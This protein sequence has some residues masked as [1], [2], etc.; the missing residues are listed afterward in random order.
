[1]SY[2][3]RIQR[4]DFQVIKEFF[5]KEKTEQFIF[6][7][8][9]KLKLSS[10]NIIY[11]VKE[12]IFPDE[13]EMSIHSKAFVAPERFFQLAVYQ[14]AC[15]K[16]Y[17]L[18]DLHNHW[19][20]KN[21]RFSEIDLSSALENAKFL[22]EHLPEI[23][24]GLAVVND[25]VNA[26]SGLVFDKSQNSFQPLEALEILGSP[27]EIFFNQEIAQEEKQETYAR[28][29]LIPNWKQKVLSDLK[30]AVVGAGGTGSIIIQALACLGV[31]E[32]K[33][34]IIIIDPDIIEK[35]NLSRIPYANE[36][37]IGKFKVKVAKNYIKQK[38][39]KINVIAIPK[40]VQEEKV[41]SF[42]KQAH[43]IIGAID[44]ENARKILNQI[45]TK[46]EVP[47]IDTGT[48]IIPEK[49]S[50]HA[51]G[52]VRIVLPRKG[53]L[54][55]INGIDLA[56]ASMEMLSEKTAQ[57]YE[58][59]GYIRGTNITPTPAVIH[60]NGVIS[61]LAISMLI[62]IIF[63]EN[64]KGQ[65]AIFYD[66]NKM[67]LVCADFEKNPKCVICSEAEEKEVENA[68][69]LSGKLQPQKR[70][71]NL[72]AHFHPSSA[73]LF[74]RKPAGKEHPGNSQQNKTHPCQ[75][76]SK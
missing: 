1:M 5:L 56:E 27:T 17:A 21:P 24:F 32:R 54:I 58:K 41:Q 45:A 10:K 23:D 15:R 68:L 49:N 57:D 52:Q 53:C 63:G 4:E 12:V 16:K 64:I 2:R 39:P 38:N 13:N 55:C 25:Q 29:Y 14:I 75:H 30:I 20:Q 65:R 35:S 40:S 36:N 11:L 6:V 26:Y 76:N 70:N 8:A 34:A 44:S 46:A 31:G 28:H 42:L 60:L 59:A 72:S 71:N 18:F 47:Y 61:Y 73:N 22:A 74:P 66:Q 43:I 67:S 51:G 62:K 9:E 50:F 33:G 37:D 3:L 69:F 19:F 7:L 48:E